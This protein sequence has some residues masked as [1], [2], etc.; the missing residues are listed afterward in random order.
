MFV[1]EISWQIP[2]EST[3][4]RLDDLSYGLLGCLRKN[5]QIVNRDFPIARVG[6]RLKTFVMMLEADALDLK[7]ANKYVLREIEKGIELGFSTPQVQII[8]ESPDIGEGITCSCRSSSYILFTNYLATGSSVRC[9]D[10][11]AHVPLY[12]LP[13]T[14]DGDEYYDLLCWQT[15]YQACDRLQMNCKTG[16][17]F[18]IQQMSDVHRSLAKQ[19]R[20]ICDKLTHSTGKPTYY[21]LWRYKLR[22]TVAQER[23]RRCPSCDG[24]WLLEDKWH[25]FD[26]KCDRC[27]LV[28]EISCTVT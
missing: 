10:C 16:E 15:D 6:D 22:T 12:H 21:A 19:G 5:G 13:K 4:E 28:S 18:G 25:E 3:P 17:R 11:F 9:G 23:Q 27:R 8:G 20:E 26:F 1:A 2:S 7:Y 14:Y 24:E